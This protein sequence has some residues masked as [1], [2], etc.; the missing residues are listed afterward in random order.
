M[1]KF[2]LGLI[3]SIIV[4]CV[5]FFGSSYFGPSF[6]IGANA[7]SLCIIYPAIFLSLLGLYLWLYKKAPLAVVGVFAGFILCILIL[8]FILSGA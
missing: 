1:K 7:G 5:Y 4:Y 6:Y 2:L 8:Q 3:I